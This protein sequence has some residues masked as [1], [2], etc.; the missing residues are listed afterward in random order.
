MKE[1]ADPAPSGT[2]SVPAAL[3]DYFEAPG[4]YQ[5]TLR[6]PAVLFRSVREILQLASGRGPQDAPQSPRL[7]EA[8]NFFIRAALLYPGADHYAVLGLAPGDAAADLKERYRLLMRLIHPDFAAG[9]NFTWPEDAAVRVNRAY[10]VLSSPVLRREYDDELATLR[11]RRPA[12]PQVAATRQ[13][14]VH[15]RQPSVTHRKLAKRTAWALAMAALIPAAMLLMPSGEPAHLVQRVPAPPKVAASHTAPVPAQDGSPQIATAPPPELIAQTPDAT[16]PPFAPPIAAAPDAPQ[17]PENTAATARAQ[18]TPAPSRPLAPVARQ[19]QASTAVAGQRIAPAAPPL[20]SSVAEVPALAPA[21]PG[22]VE[23]APRAALPAVEV[24][25]ATSTRPAIA[26]AMPVATV[27]PAGRLTTTLAVPQVPVPTLN[28]AQPILTQMLQTLE[29]GSG[30]QLLRLLDSEARNQ[31]GAQALSRKYEQLVKGGRPIQVADVEFSAEPREGL[32]LV[33][34]RVRLHAGEPTIGSFG[35]KL[36][37]RAEFVQ[38]AGKTQ[39]N[40]LSSAS[41]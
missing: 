14:A 12:A 24:P 15:H 38:R 18:E 30:E 10:E 31:A 27:A 40:A 22:A 11:A 3:L 2:S 21:G 32:L 37:L 13:R 35:Q 1:A 23:S 8:A 26:V 20:V 34:G 5:L 9:A 29:S 7:R 6:Q 39:L 16:S 36:V 33:T 4:K 25:V 41:E 28:D 17:R 19:D